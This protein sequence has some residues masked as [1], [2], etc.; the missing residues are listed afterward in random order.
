VAPGKMPRLNQAGSLGP[1][2]GPVCV[3]PEAV[4]V[5]EFAGS[6]VV[7]AA[8]SVADFIVGWTTFLSVATVA[9]ADCGETTGTGLS[10]PLQARRRGTGGAR[11]GE[12]WRRTV[13]QSCAAARGCMRRGVAT[14]LGH[15]RDLDDAERSITQGV[16]AA[17]GCGP[18][19]DAER[20]DD[21]VQPPR[22]GPARRAAGAPQAAA[23]GVD[24]GPVGRPAG[25]LGRARGGGAAAG[26]RGDAGG[27]V[28]G[29]AELR[30]VGVHR[31]SRAAGAAG[32]AGAP[33]GGGDVPVPAAGA[34]RVRGVQVRRPEHESWR[35][36]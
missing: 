15:A 33:A 35:A 22:P 34:G 23:E 30:R 1:G 19:G 32:G 13:Y 29:V 6:G 17:G 14:R 18:H 24:V 2:T 28:A 5:G 31:Q 20:G 9:P 7:G 4:S 11:G 21:R 36:A 8:G 3:P 10:L 12:A 26:D 16:L 27:V 25:G